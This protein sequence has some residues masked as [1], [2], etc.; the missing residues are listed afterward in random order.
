AVHAPDG[1]QGAEGGLYLEGGTAHRQ[2]GRA[3][4]VEAQ[5]KRAGRTRDCDRLRRR[6]LELELGAVLHFGRAAAEGLRILD[7]ERALVDERGG[8]G[9]GGSASREA[10]PRSRARIRKGRGTWNG[11]DNVGAIVAG[12]TDP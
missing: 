6:R 9:C 10:Q 11:G 8:S 4:A 3:F 5:S 7:L 1:A 12:V 2:R